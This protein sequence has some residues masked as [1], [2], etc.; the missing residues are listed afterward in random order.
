MSPMEQSIPVEE[1]RGSWRSRKEVRPLTTDERASFAIVSLYLATFCISAFVYTDSLMLKILGITAAIAGI[2]LFVA[3][4]FNTE[5]RGQSNS[6][7]P[8]RSYLISFFLVLLT[9][10][11]LRLVGGLITQSVFSVVVMYAGLLVALVVFR[12][13][14]LQVISTVLALTF[15][16]VTFLN[17]N[18]ILA[19]R[20]GFI[21]AT[22]Q[23]GHA[24]FQIGPIQ[25][26]ANMLLAGSYVT[27]LNH[28]DYRNEQLIGLAAKKVAKCN[29]DDL[30]KTAV[31]LHFVSNEIHYVS[32]PNDGLEYAKA[33]LNTLIDTAGDC[34]DQALLLCTL[35]ECVGVK[36]YMAFTDDHVFVL[37]RFS[38]RYSELSA[39]P[40]GF[41]D[42]TPC[43]ALDP[44]DPNAAI[45]T[46]SAKPGQIKRVFDVR[47]KSLVHFE[48]TLSDQM[49]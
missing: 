27:Y 18:D 5:A 3:A 6:I 33:P 7:H 17:L 21:D 45:G 15:L 44:S 40:F 28:I 14:M 25:D 41:I 9:L 35:L 23:C 39:K 32:D 22:R 1:S 10:F 24:L 12:K 47:D 42:G 29:D 26:V 31:L 48:S 36:T 13:A 20:M 37:V 11:V 34:E 49:Q 38:K 46:T 43:F 8:L 16:F 19:R 2:F 4:F 30:Q